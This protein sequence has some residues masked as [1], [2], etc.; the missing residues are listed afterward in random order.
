MQTTSSCY[1]E[2]SS[3]AGRLQVLAIY[4]PSLPILV[5]SFSIGSQNLWIGNSLNVGNFL[6]L[7][8]NFRIKC[9]FFPC[10]SKV[11][12]DSKEVAVTSVPNMIIM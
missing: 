8:E 5:H 6:A 12:K 2:G 4:L 9:S 7:E 1:N 3:K 11:T 10:H